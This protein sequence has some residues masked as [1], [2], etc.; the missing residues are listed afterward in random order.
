[1]RKLTS[2]KS[3]KN[4]YSKRILSNV[5]NKDPL[6]VYERS[7]RELQR[8]AAGLNSKQLQTPINKGKWSIGQIVSHLCDAEITISY[9]LRMSIAQSGGPIQAYDQ[10]K[11]ADALYREKSSCSEHVKLFSVL[12]NANVSLLKGLSSKEWQ[13]YGMHEERGK[14]TVERMV[15]MTAGHDVNH[16]R[17]IKEIRDKF[18]G[19][20]R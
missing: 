10:D 14:E 6:K 7:P 1:M 12:R 2:V 3:I 16:L 20:S 15:Q 5:L 4:P 9:R 11:W 13:R 19:R 18:L 17:Q 8:L